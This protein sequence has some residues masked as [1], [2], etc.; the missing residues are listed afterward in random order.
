M[1]RRMGR[2]TSHVWHSS[3]DPPPSHH[4]QKRGETDVQSQ[5]RGSLIPSVL[6][7][8]YEVPAIVS[9]LWSSF[10]PSPWSQI[11][12]SKNFRTV[13]ETV[14]LITAHASRVGASVGD[15]PG[16]LHPQLHL[17]W[18]TLILRATSQA[19]LGA[20]HIWSQ[21]KDMTC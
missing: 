4:S 21:M 17:G 8:E 3:L 14:Y 18:G 10:K 11:H 16:P 5:G 7:S 12:I 19:S 15:H 2:K 13:G 6:G 20:R 1:L 9:A